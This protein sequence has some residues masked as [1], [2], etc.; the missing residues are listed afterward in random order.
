MQTWPQRLAEGQVL[1][2]QQAAELNPAL[3]VT[4][5]Y[6]PALSGW[7]VSSLRTKWKGLAD[8]GLGPHPRPAHSEAPG[9]GPRNLCMHGPLGQSHAHFSLRSLI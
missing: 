9:A 2:L 4:K 3:G 1:H 6:S 8:A 5:T 7:G